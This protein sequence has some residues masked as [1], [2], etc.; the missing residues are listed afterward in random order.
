LY[1]AQQEHNEGTLQKVQKELCDFTK[2]YDDDISTVSWSNEKRET[3]SEALGLEELMRFEQLM[4]R[5]KEQEN[6][7][8]AT[9]SN[10]DDDN[11]DDNDS[12]TNDD[13]DDSDGD[14]D[15]TNDSSSSST[16]TS[17]P[18]SKPHPTSTSSKR[19]LLD[20]QIG[21][22]EECTATDLISSMLHLKPS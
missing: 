12:D 18:G 5:Q 3:L 22:E 7:G 14:D 4:K 13:D 20:D 1:W 10:D 21:T 6:N 17:G 11:D 19:I 8:G 15:S 16:T 2:E 9:A